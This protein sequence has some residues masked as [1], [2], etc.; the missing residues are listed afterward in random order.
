MDNNPDAWRLSL[1]GQVDDLIPIRDYASIDDADTAAYLYEVLKEA[2]KG[3]FPFEFILGEILFIGKILG[4]REER[5]RRRREV[6]T[7]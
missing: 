3:L 6:K 5:A 4:K 7:A 2:E 1:R